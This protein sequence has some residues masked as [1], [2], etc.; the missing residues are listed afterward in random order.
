M[1]ISSHLKSEFGRYGTF[2]KMSYTKYKDVLSI[3]HK[4][5]YIYL[6]D[7]RLYNDEDKSIFLYKSMKEL[8]DK[9]VLFVETLRVILQEN[10]DTIVERIEE[11]EV[12]KN[13]C[14]DIISL[15]SLFNFYNI[16]INEIDHEIKQ[17]LEVIIK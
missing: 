8:Y 17:Q 16:N 5:G 4:A 10:Y 3:H 1:K 9:W 2:M 7:R 11:F 13:D 12:I 15:E 14:I 6:G